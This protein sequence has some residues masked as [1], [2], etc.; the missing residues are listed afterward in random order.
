MDFFSNCKDIVIR[1]AILRALEYHFVNYLCSHESVHEVLNLSEYT[2]VAGLE[3]GAKEAPR[4]LVSPPYL[5]NTIE[6]ASGE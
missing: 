2:D 5:I 6:H 4:S 1:N 3:R